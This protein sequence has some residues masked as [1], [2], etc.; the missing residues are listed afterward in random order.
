MYR[1]ALTADDSRRCPRAKRCHPTLGAGA[2][3][4]AWQSRSRADAE[5]PLHGL[6]KVARVPNYLR[7]I[8]LAGVLLFAALLAL[9]ALFFFRPTPLLG[10]DGDSL[11]RSLNGLL[12]D[13]EDCRR[14]RNGA[15]EP[16]E[17]FKWDDGRSGG[18]QYRVKV[19]RW[20]CWEAKRVGPP[21][22]EGG[23]PRSLSGCVGLLS[24]LG[25]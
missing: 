6:P 19:D 5:P 20:G 11:S 15:G 24:H 17:C 22:G 12:N 16:W 21:A 23:T 13:A 1:S 9:A 14:E 18:A 4:L 10:V 3:R 2:A 7:A 8:A 25:I